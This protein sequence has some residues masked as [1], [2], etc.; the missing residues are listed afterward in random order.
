MPRPVGAGCRA[1]RGGKGRLGCSG[2]GASVESSQGMPGPARSCCAASGAAS[3][4][5]AQLYTHSERQRRGEPHVLLHAV[6]ACPDHHHCLPP[7]ALPASAGT[8]D[9]DSDYA[10]PSASAHDLA[11]RDM[12]TRLAKKGRVRYKEFSSDGALGNLRSA[13]RA[14]QLL[15]WAGCS[16]GLAGRAP[17]ALLSFLRAAGQGPRRGCPWEG[18]GRGDERPGGGSQPAGQAGAGWQ[19]QAHRALPR[20]ASRLLFPPAAQACCRQQGC[21]LLRRCCRGHRQHFIR[22][23]GSGQR[24]RQRAGKL[25]E[26]GGRGGG[27]GGG[28]GALRLGRLGLRGGRGGFER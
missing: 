3:A 19:A 18:G 2:A 27:G 11:G 1:G 7:P 25:R 5:H 13:Q 28:F 15:R 17:Q 24:Q 14:Q 26:R 12:S 6:P 8:S 20:G 9:S 4:L 21:P 22:G 16:A 10:G 23:G